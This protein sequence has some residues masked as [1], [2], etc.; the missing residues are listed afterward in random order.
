MCCG[1][2]ELC[3]NGDGVDTDVFIFIYIYLFIYLFIYL[4]Y[5]ELQFLL[6]QI[7]S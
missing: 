3:Q 5:N 2:I 1:V 4:L 6:L 7:N